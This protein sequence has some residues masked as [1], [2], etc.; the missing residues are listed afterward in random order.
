MAINQIMDVA[1]AIA[2]HVNERYPTALSQHN[3]LNLN[4]R[5]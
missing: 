1:I 3:Q 2:R 4:S 5:L